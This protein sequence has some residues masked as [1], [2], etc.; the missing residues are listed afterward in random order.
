MKTIQFFIFIITSFIAVVGHAAVDIKHWQTSQG[1]QVYFVEN[2]DLPILDL[3]VNFPAGSA[4]DAAEKSGLASVTRYMMSLGA[5]GMSEE[6]ITNQFADIGAILGGSFDMDRAS[7]KLRTLSSEQD[8]ALDTFKKILHHPDFPQAVLEREKARIISS[9]KESD[10]QPDSIADKAFMKALYGSHPYSLDGSGEVDT[11]D[12]ITSE[13]LRQF[14]Q[15]YYTAKSAVIA[16]I[17]DVTEA[18]AREISE[19]ISAGLPQTPAVGEISSVQPLTQPSKQEIA[20]PATQAHILV[21][22]P[23]IHRGDPD[24]FPLYV[25]NYILGGGGFVSRLTEE[26]RE[27]RGL[28]YSVYSYFMPMAEKGPFE[29]GLQTKKEQA[30]DALKL[31]NETVATFVNKGVTEKELKAAKDNIIGGF[32]MRIDSNNKILD[33]LSVIGFYHLPLTYLD[34]FNKQ[35]A[36]VTTKQINDAFK[37]KVKPESFATVIVGAQ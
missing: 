17:G 1:A 34:D 9:L 28:V 14:Y 13:D 6:V 15:T 24:Y 23:G 31:V 19:S 5:A 16:L 18:Q 27:K 36:K 37:R 32:P 11:I 4:R 26:V 3:G 7:Y 29:I 35:I 2:H 33:Y 21:G 25:G 22:Q 8:K 30:N 12:K 20:H 10:T